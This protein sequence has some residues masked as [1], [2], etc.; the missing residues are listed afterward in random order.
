MYI[1]VSTDGPQSDI[2]GHQESSLSLR[3]GLCVSA[4]LNSLHTAP[5]KIKAPP[6]FWSPKS[7]CGYGTNIGEMESKWTVKGEHFNMIEFF[8]FLRAHA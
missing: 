8:F 7:D 6:V 4:S 1:H 3:H 2:I 5:L